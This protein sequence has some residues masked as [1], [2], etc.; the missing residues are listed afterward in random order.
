MKCFKKVGI[1]LVVLV[2]VLSLVVCGG[3][4]D[5]SKFGL[6]DEK[7]LMVFVDVGYK[8]YVNKIKGDFEKDNDVKVKVVEKDMFEIL[9]VLL[10]DG[11]V[12]IVLDVMMF[13]FDRI[14]SLG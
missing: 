6:F 13:V 11:L 9:E 12:G 1:V 10:F 14:G 5:I 8:D 3:G 7:I 2:M 4:K